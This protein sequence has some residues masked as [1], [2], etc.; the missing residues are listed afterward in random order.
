MLIMT[1]TAACNSPDTL[2]RTFSFSQ[3]FVEAAFQLPDTFCEGDTLSIT[4]ASVN[5]TGYHWM[6]GDGTNSTAENPSHIFQDPGT[7]TVRLVTTNP[8]SCNKADTVSRT[9]T[10]NPNPTAAFAYT[11]LIPETNVPTNFIN[12][13]QHATRY[14]WTFGDGGSSVEINPVHQYPKTGTYT[15]CLT[16]YNNLGCSDRVCRSVSADVLPLADVPTRLQ[17]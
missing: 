15:V 9:I 11:P 14:Q 10:I 17:P 8:A 13:S 16:A 5:G 1:D 7:Y 12:Q 3:L 6:F 2:I 4:N